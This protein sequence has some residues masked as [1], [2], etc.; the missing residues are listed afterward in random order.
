MPD[1]ST[2]DA[3]N[4]LASLSVRLTTAVRRFFASPARRDAT[5]LV[6]G[7]VSGGVGVIV[8][9]ADLSLWVMVVLSTLVAAL[10]LVIERAATAATPDKRVRWLWA[11]LGVALVLPTGTWAYHGLFDSDHRSTFPSYLEGDQIPTLP[12]AG[13]P[14]GPPQAGGQFLPTGQSYDFECNARDDEGHLWLK[15]AAGNYWYEASLFTP[16][17]DFTTADMPTC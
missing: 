16:V 15:A 13:K 8:G 14:G 1:D 11:A 7:L 4:P 5:A 2:D 6:I 10:F 3:S 17:G 9:A 12:S